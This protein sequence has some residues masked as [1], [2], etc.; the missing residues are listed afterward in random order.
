MIKVSGK[1]KYKYIEM[2]FKD[3]WFISLNKEDVLVLSK[4]W[5]ILN[6]AK[7]RGGF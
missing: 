2:I 7:N 1:S 4:I 3:E 5:T 6:R